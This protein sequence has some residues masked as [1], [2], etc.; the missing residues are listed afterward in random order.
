MVKYP[1]D[2]KL[3]L[4]RLREYAEISECPRGAYNIRYQGGV[5]IAEWRPEYR[6]CEECSRLC[7]QPRS[8]TYFLQ[9]GVWR[10][11]CTGCRYYHDPRTGS[12]DRKH[13]PLKTRTPVACQAADATA[14]IWFVP[15][16]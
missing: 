5:E 8:I 6:T 11:Y 10:R 7:D 13:T 9:K 3:F 15:E 1:V 4:Q 2:H 14:V 12:W 16:D